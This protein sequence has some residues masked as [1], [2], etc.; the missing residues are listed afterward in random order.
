MHPERLDSLGVEFVRESKRGR[1]EIVVIEAGTSKNGNHYSDETLKAAVDLFDGRPL[2]VYE[3]TES[4]RGHLPAKVQA[5]LNGGIVQNMIG[6]IQ[7][8][9]GMKRAA[10]SS[11]RR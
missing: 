5:A 9:G 1:W 7:S 11:P 8:P 10:P 4:Y 2:Q 3:L 6:V